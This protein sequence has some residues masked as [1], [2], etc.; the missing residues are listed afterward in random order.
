[1]TNH[2]FKESELREARATERLLQDS[3]QNYR[4]RVHELNVAIDDLRKQQE[5]AHVMQVSEF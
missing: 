4:D 3:I 5:E 1:V 2:Y